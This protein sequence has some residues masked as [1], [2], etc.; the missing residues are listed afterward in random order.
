M[1]SIG[2]EQVCVPVI[3]LATVLDGTPGYLRITETLLW[4]CLD[5][6]LTLNIVL[7]GNRV[8]QF[9]NWRRW[10]RKCFSSLDTPAPASQP[11]LWACRLGDCV[12]VSYVL[13]DA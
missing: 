2:R 12:E 7:I 4:I 10:W 5:A 1:M 8:E 6:H 11:G 9:T 3:I 13:Q